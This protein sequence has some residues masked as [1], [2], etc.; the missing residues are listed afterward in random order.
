MIS[1]IGI[2]CIYPDAFSPI[3]LWN[4]VLSK[5]KAFRNIPK[6]RIDLSYYNDESND[7]IYIKKAALIKNY[8]FDRK[9]FQISSNVF[10]SADLTHWLALDVAHRTLTDSGFM[11]GNGLNKEKTAVVV[12]NTLT[13]EFSRSEL[14]RL[15][16]PYV[17]RLLETKLSSLSINIQDFISDFEKSYKEPFN[18]PNEDSLSGGLSNT[19]AGRI[20]NYFN[21][22]GGCFTVD[23]ACSS[24]LVAITQACN[25]LENNSIDYALVGGVDLSLDPFELIGFS[26]ISA[27]SRGDMKV[28]DKNSDGFLP[29]EGCGFVLLT[30]TEN[31]IENGIKKYC[32]I[33]GWGISSDGSGGL[34]RPEIGGQKLAI[35][36]AYEKGNISPN[37]ITLFEGHGTGTVIGDYTELSALNQ[38]LNN[39]NNKH[40]IGS[41]KTNIGHTKAAA[42]IAGLIKSI[43]SLQT[44]II[45]PITSNN[46][47]HEEI[48][49]ID[50]K[51][52]I[53]QKS[54]PWP[55]DRS[56]IAGVSSFGFGG[57]N[58]HVIL[59]NPV[60]NNRN[61]LSQIQEKH[62]KTYQD[63]E[64]I[65]ID[66]NSKNILLQKIDTILQK[67]QSLSLAELCDLSVSLIKKIDHNSKYRLSIVCNSVSDLIDKL[68]KTKIE[69]SN[70]SFIFNKSGI[71]YS[72]NQNFK[73]SYVFPGQAA[74]VRFD[75]GIIDSWNI[76]EQNINSIKNGNITDTSIA[77]P[78]IINSEYNCYTL[79]KQLNINPDYVI[80][81][82]LGE[83]MSL[84][85]VDIIDKNTLW[86]LTKNRGDIMQ[87]FSKEGK[88]IVVFIENIKIQN[89]LKEY[90]SIDIAGY[91]SSN[92]VVLS[93]PS[94]QIILLCNFLKENNIGYVTL[95]ITRMF[96]SRHMEQA[97]KKWKQLLEITDFNKHNM[98]HNYIS[99]I[100]GEIIK[101][102]DI[103]N[104]LTKQ[105]T[106]PVLFTKAL[107]IIDKK[108]TL[109]IE[110]GP[111]NILDNLITS[112]GG[113]CV[114][115]DFGSQS[116]FGI[117][118]SIGAIFSIT[119]KNIDLSLLIDRFSKFIDIESKDTFFSNPCEIDHEK[120]Y[121]IK[122]NPDKIIIDDK[123]EKNPLSIIKQLISLKT[124]L[125]TDSIR[126]TDNFLKDLHLNS[127]N[128]G[129][130]MAEACKI[131]NIDVTIP[132][133]EFSNKTLSES[134]LLLEEIISKSNN[135]NIYESNNIEGVSTW[136]QSY[137]I[138][139]EKQNSIESK[140]VTITDQSWR[141]AYDKNYAFIEQ[142]QIISKKLIGKGVILC[143]NKTIDIEF[144]LD[145]TQK[146]IKDKIQNLLVIQHSD[147]Y[148]SFFRTL[149]QET[150]IK[151]LVVK[152]PEQN[153]DSQLI[154]NEFYNNQKKFNYIV[155][156]SLYN[157]YIESFKPIEKSINNQ[158]INDKD[159]IVVT[160]GAKGIT[161][162][163]AKKL[164]QETNC[165]LAIIGRSNKETIKNNLEIFEKFD[166]KYSY[167]TADV[168]DKNQIVSTIKNIHNDY[169][170]ITG[171]I[172]G[173]GT[174]TPC[175]IND[176]NLE[177]FN[178]TYNPKVIGLKN[179]LDAIDPNN[180]KI[181][182]NFGSIIGRLGMS[183]QADYALS[184]AITS[185]MT[186]EFKRHHPSIH[187]LSL[188]WSVWSEVGMG[189]NLGKIES[190][191]NNG[192]IP[193]PVKDGIAEFISLINS[194]T[195]SC[196]VP[197]ISR[198]GNICEFNNY[199]S[200][201][202]P[203]LRFL[204]KIRVYYPNVELVTDFELSEINDL[205]LGDHE[206]QGEKIFPAV[207]MIEAVMQSYKALTGNKAVPQIQNIVFN[208]PI[209]INKPTTIRVC[210]LKNKNSFKIAIRSSNTNYKIDHFLCEINC[211]ENSRPFEIIDMPEDNDIKIDY[212]YK[213]L[214][215]QKNRF[216]NI[217]HYYQLSAYE[218]YAE[219]KPQS[220]DIYFD[221]SFPQTMI[222][223]DP[224]VR[225]S[226]LHSLQCCVPDKLLLPAKIENIQIL[227]TNY[228]EKKIAYAYRIWEKEDEYCYDLMI[229][230]T[231]G[232]VLEIW[233]NI[234]LRVLQ[235]VNYIDWNKD[236]LGCHIKRLLSEKCDITIFF[237]DINDGIVHRIDGKPE[238]KD[239]HVSKSYCD[240]IVLVAKS[241][242]YIG[243]DIQSIKPYQE[244]LLN[245]AGN[246]L[247][248]IIKQTSQE[249]DDILQ[250]RIWT[251]FESIKKS[252]L[253]LNEPI[254]I[255]TITDNFIK[256]KIAEYKIYSFLRK[257]DNI[258]YCI[259][260]LVYE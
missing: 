192:I 77:Q 54:I 30:K 102:N 131:L 31:A 88:M 223:G 147:T 142:S 42:G 193:I 32:D 24:S 33:I 229:C 148:A 236:L 52:C 149:Q 21:F 220:N 65:I 151:V 112:D 238:H 146:I 66:A 165:T 137:N 10:N 16:W 256:L 242:Y 45:P 243:C 84:Y 87:N 169:G 57:I 5:R 139:L 134:A 78:C 159:V 113:Y 18:E 46:N 157:R 176:L 247:F 224:G 28:Y 195:E 15:R 158:R 75:N 260:F 251:I 154:I 70:N 56:L 215:F 63:Y 225:D 116:L 241:K 50:S 73:I 213:K 143:L 167:Y 179:L 173:A 114:S 40:F 164:A 4:N 163:C 160:G 171:L 7:S 252:G 62:N 99:T 23:G 72:E 8:N 187:C 3:E 121:S 79:F 174:N 255:D 194:E 175:L 129:Q 36:R 51:L 128:V 201:E 246:N 117:L 170:K 49:K 227:N 188:E 197:I 68:N 202:I 82:S 126:D 74:P 85:S 191:I 60:P 13:G 237:N 34:T 95:P 69:L 207:M 101:D 6:S 199:S 258:N 11:D 216:A 58:S 125:S 204:E 240:N 2:G 26:R 130:I 140:E 184:N 249:Q 181:M 109:F 53:S 150:N 48:T 161:Y 61:K 14:M 107:S 106:E 124:E 132:L 25:L 93:G 122:N 44:Q 103:I 97:A 230:D 108:N 196:I 136:V 254:T 86:N 190:L 89:I 22:N 257:I 83:L 37:D 155:Y 259:T 232:K 127:I 200:K 29:G 80:G 141:I 20:S 206:F 226:C 9:K 186:A 235:P 153:Y 145:E 178:K 182:I 17:K 47:P 19:I 35:Q 110:V 233:K 221:R 218:S 81:H 43:M 222:I 123:K 91:N 185:D 152:L 253:N 177:N 76:K 217:D 248:D 180:L 67:C 120:D 212:M 133:S 100:N 96:H 166:I 239:Y 189:A 250:T 209:V 119:D 183:G 214:L 219:I 138:I 90:N 64:L 115:T 1:I 244:K 205:Y 231:A 156:D 71:Y 168:C 135:K 41:I 55:K 92:Q 211:Q 27:M 203:F 118:S 228:S 234:L 94:D 210:C 104:L 162:E 38:I 172:H 39:S 12:G 208:Q 198:L 111:G 144:L 105:F 59:H 98:S 245:D